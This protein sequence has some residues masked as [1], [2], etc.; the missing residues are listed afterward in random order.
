MDDKRR[1]ETQL[2]QLEEELEE[3]RITSES[4]SD[5]LK[6]LRAKY[7]QVQLDCTVLKETN[8]DLE[9]YL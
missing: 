8:A 2:N 3:E 7:A 1:I 4:N 5:E 6:N 9:V